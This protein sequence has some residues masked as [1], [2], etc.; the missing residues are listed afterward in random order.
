MACCMCHVEIILDHVLCIFVCP[1]ALFYFIVVCNKLKATN[2][3]KMHPL[4]ADSCSNQRILL[5]LAASATMIDVT[6]HTQ[7]F[8]LYYSLVLYLYFLHTIAIGLPQTLLLIIYNL[9]N[10]SQCFIVKSPKT[11]IG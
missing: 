5:T 9:Y 7:I 10:S 2:E 6:D 4:P 8:S 3:I 11:I 1:F